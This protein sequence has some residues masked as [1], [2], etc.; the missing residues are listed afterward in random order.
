MAS[1]TE[2]C[3]GDHLIHLIVF[4]Q[5]NSEGALNVVETAGAPVHYLPPPDVRTDW[6]RPTDYV[7]FCEWKGAGVH[8]DLVIDDVRVAHAAFTY[9]DPLDDLGRGYPQIAGWFGARS[10]AER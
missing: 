4:S 2:D 1:F 10:S 8:F 5:Q 9:P 7:T 6:L 3:C